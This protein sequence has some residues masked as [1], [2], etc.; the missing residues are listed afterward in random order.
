MGHLHLVYNKIMSLIELKDISKHYHT[1]DTETIAL[2][3]I[4]LEIK[5]G[6]FAAI[7]GPSG[8]GKST[9]MHILGLLDSPSTGEY[10]L[11]GKNVLANKDSQLA[12]LR[13]NSIGFVFQSFNLLPRLSVLQNVMLPMAYAGVPARKRKDKA[14]KLLKTVGVAERANHRLNQISGGQTQRV[15]VARSLANGP[16]LILADEPTGNLD[17]K[18]SQVIV[19]L[20]KNLNKEGHTIIIVTHN[21]EIAEQTD[22]IIEI[23]DGHIVADSKAGTLKAKSHKRMVI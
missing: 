15:A 8:S 4:N 1:G 11:D 6:E 18:A 22:R 13:R 12:K 23:R 14:L 20:L 17:T 7:V 5:E 16:K 3:D 2:T 10:I 21:P 19:D 9:L